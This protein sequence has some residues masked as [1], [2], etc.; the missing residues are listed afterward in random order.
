MGRCQNGAEGR[1]QAS[2]F[3]LGR[4]TNYQAG[5]IV[6]N[7]P[8]FMGVDIGDVDQLYFGVSLGDASGNG[9]G[10]AIA[11]AVIFYEKY[12]HKRFCLRLGFAPGAVAV[13][14]VLFVVP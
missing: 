7:F 9:L 8:H 3:S 6:G 12:R 2:L 13:K 4:H 5:S 14:P 10:D 11:V 1:V